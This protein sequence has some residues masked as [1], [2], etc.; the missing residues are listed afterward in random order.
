MGNQKICWKAG[1]GLAA[2]NG[3]VAEVEEQAGGE[4]DGGA[5]IEPALAP[6]PELTV[7]EEGASS[8]ED[9]TQVEQQSI[10]GKLSIQVD[11]EEASE[12]MEY[13]EVTPVGKGYA[14]NKL[15]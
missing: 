15:I 13:K 7:L 11:H 2:G 9:Q 5:S 4:D 3:M 8:R 12:D 1:D 6:Q 10:S 14:F